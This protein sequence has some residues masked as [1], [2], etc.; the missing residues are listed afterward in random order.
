[1]PCAISKTRLATACLNGVFNSSLF[2]YAAFPLISTCPLLSI[3]LISQPIHLFL[4]CSPHPTCLYFILFF[5]TSLFP[6][7]PFFV[8]FRFA[9]TAFFRLHLFLPLQSPV[10]PFVFHFNLPV[11]IHLLLQSPAYTISGTME[12]SMAM[13]LPALRTSL[14]P[15]LFSRSDNPPKA[16]S[17][18]K[19]GLGVDQNPVY[20]NPRY[21]EFLG[22]S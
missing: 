1:M 18:A 17:K 22:F 20:C 2:L 14:A 6:E 16:F 19:E 15:A 21:K 9:N 13:T 4:L 12:P 10:S 8:T 5:V 3:F 7:F 11:R